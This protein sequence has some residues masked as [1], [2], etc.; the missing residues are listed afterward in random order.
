MVYIQRS[1]VFRIDRFAMHAAAIPLSDRL[2]PTCSSVHKVHRLTFNGLLGN[3]QGQI[4]TPVQQ[5]LEQQVFGCA[6][7]TDVVDMIKELIL[8]HGIGCVKHLLHV[9]AVDF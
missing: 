9:R 3:G 7:F 4:Y 1:V 8:C 2:F 5:H 6:V